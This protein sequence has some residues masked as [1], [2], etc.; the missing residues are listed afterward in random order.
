MQERSEAELRATASSV[1]GFDEGRPGVARSIFDIGRCNANSHRIDQASNYTSFG[2]QI[3]THIAYE[4]VVKANFCNIS[5]S[6]FKKRCTNKV[7]TNLT[8]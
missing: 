7:Q 8:G 1:V 5:R 6:R 4:T 3:Y 2:P